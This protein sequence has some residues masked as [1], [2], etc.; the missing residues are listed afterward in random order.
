MFEPKD[1]LNDYDELL[2]KKIHYINGYRHCLS[3]SMKFQ[4]LYWLRM[5]DD[6]AIKSTLLRYIDEP[7]IPKFYPMKREY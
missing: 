6:Y 3:D 7:H 5:D 2:L 1:P 4:K